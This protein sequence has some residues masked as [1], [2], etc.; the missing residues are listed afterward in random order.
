MITVGGSL[1]AQSLA[2]TE[3]GRVAPLHSR[4]CSIVSVSASV[5]HAC[6]KANACTE[7]AIRHI[8]ASVELKKKRLRLEKQVKIDFEFDCAEVEKERKQRE[9]ELNKK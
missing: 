1:P 8:G 9:F 7:L 4:L 6:S 3:L 2:A 5:I